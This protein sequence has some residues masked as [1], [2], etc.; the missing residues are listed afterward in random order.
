L[1]ERSAAVEEVPV[2]A[3][4]EGAEGAPAAADGDAAKESTDKK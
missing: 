3:A 4:V 1:S 2:V